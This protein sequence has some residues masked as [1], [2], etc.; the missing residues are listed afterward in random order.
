MII[1]VSRWKKK[2]L[3][4]LTVI[5]L[6]LA[7]AFSIPFFTGAVY[8]QIPVISSWF[9]KENPTGNPLRVDNEQDGTKFEEMVNQ[10]VIKLQDF[11]YE[12]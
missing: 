11:Y 4:V 3:K 5:V 1:L 9:E 10:L 8:R 6:L 2:L 12:K 7:F